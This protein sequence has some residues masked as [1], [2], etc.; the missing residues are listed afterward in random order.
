[1]KAIF[2]FLPENFYH[3]TI[4]VPNKDDGENVW[5]FL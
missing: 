5:N 3:F 2:A 1:M 4:D